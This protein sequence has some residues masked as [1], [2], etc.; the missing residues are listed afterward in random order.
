MS[1]L[2]LKIPPVLVAA[3]F[4]ALVWLV[5]ELTPGL[6]ITIALRTIFALLLTAAATFIGFAAVA[7]F[8]KARTTVNPLTPEACSSLVDSGVFSFTRNPMYLA[9]LFILAGW[10]VFL[11]NPLSLATTVLFIGYM[12]RFQIIPEERALEAAFG[13]TFLQY[14]QQVRRWL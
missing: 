5:S 12:N 6:D 1:V 4:A 2:E 14:K 11:G 13:E 7:T 10:A 3:L 9:L 8:R